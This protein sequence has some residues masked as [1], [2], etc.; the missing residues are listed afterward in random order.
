MFGLCLIGVV[1]TMVLCLCEDL[2]LMIRFALGTL[3]GID[4]VFWWRRSILTYVLLRQRERYQLHVG[5]LR[6]KEAEAGDCY[7]F[8]GEGHVQCF[9]HFVEGACAMSD[10]NSISVGLQCILDQ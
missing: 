4:F 6:L 3:F 2:N 10:L 1:I 7:A 8:L 9:M 5:L